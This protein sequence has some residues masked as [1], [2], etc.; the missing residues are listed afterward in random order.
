[1]TYEEIFDRLKAMRVQGER[2]ALTYE[3]MF[4]AWK[5]LFYAMTYDEWSAF[6]DA[7]LEFDEEEFDPD[8]DAAIE[9]ERPNR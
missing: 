9:P 5:D 7:L 2:P 3:E 1:M 8:K 6:R 4:D